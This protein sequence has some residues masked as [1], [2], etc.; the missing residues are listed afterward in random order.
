MLP[1]SWFIHIQGETFGPLSADIVT[2]ML[3]QQRLHFSDFAWAEGMKKWTRLG[4]TAPFENMMPPYPDA[5]IPQAGKGEE[6]APR[7]TP[8]PKVA[9]A[10]ALVKRGHGAQAAA[11]VLIEETPEPAPPP[12][13]VIPKLAPK[14]V[15]VRRRERVE[16]HATVMLADRVKHRVLNISETGVFIK[17]PRG[18]EVGTDVK[19]TLESPEFPKPLEMTGILIRE[20]Q[21]DGENAVALE[22][23]RV[24]PAHRRILKEYVDSQLSK[25]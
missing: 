1:K 7:R 22:F 15:G 17:A 18:V 5:P 11:A 24:N 23:T 20:D 19:F 8:S 12:P 9:A 6:E 10:L 16:I 25:K 2:L 14:E 21:E 13:V 3:R 4:E